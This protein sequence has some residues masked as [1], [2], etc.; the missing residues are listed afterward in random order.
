MG[1]ANVSTPKP[2][3]NTE[4]E[5]HRFEPVTLKEVL[6]IVKEINIYKDS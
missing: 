6:D 3:W 2:E 5:R 1:G 4:D